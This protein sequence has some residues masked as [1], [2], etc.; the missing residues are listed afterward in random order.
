MLRY[1]IVYFKSVPSKFNH[2]ND[3]ACIET[4]TRM[5]VRFRYIIFLSTILFLP[6]H[7]IMNR[8]WSNTN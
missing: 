8:Y 1:V 6:I 5:N 4:I 3:T 2:N 7:I